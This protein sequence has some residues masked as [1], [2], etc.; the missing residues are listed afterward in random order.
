VP[1]SDGVGIIV[2]TGSDVKQLKAGDRVAGLFFPK[3]ISGKPAPKL[4]QGSLGGSS[5]DGM[6]QQ[7]IVLDE[8][9]LIKVPAYLRDVQAATLPCAALVA[10]HGLMEE[11]NIHKGDTVL[12]Q[13]SGAVSLFSLQFAKLLGANVI[14]LSGS[15]EKLE[16]LH[17]LGADH[18]INYRKYPGWE[19]LVLDITG[20]RGVDH[21]AEVAGAENINRSIEV[22]AMGGTIAVIGLMNGFKGLINTAD[23]MEKNIR[24]QG[25]VVGSKQMFENMNKA[26]EKNNLIPVVDK[27]FPFEETKKALKYFETE[28][29]FGKICIS[30]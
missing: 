11:G 9:E 4:L 17:R 18:L 15:D 12:I 10:W 21:V 30:M 29:Y 22:T 26:L 23:I 24:L 28:N 3:W 6:L 13:G 14:A 16:R 25:V 19:K 20:G 8:T 1:L 5:R 7:Q 27:V 2:Q